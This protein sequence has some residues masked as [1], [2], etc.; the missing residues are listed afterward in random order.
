MAFFGTRF[1]R[2]GGRIDGVSSPSNLLL[3]G[4]E[5]WITDDSL[6]TV[7]VSDSIGLRSRVCRVAIANPNST[8][9]NRYSLMHRV[10]VVDEF[11]LITFSGRVIDKRPDFGRSELHLTCVDYLSDISDTTILADDDG[12]TYSGKSRAHIINQILYNEIW[13]SLSVGHNIGGQVF[14]VY[15]DHIRTLLSRV[16]MD[17]SNYVEKLT[18]TYSTK[19]YWTDSNVNP[20]GP[21]ALNPDTPFKYD[22]RGIKTGLE[23]IQDLAS[24][25]NQQ[26]L[27]VLGMVSGSHVEPNA[28]SDKK[29]TRYWKDFTADINE[30]E[31]AFVPLNYTVAHNKLYIGS[32]SKFNG[33]TYTFH[34]RGNSMGDSDYGNDTLIW[35]YWD[36]TQWL[37]FDNEIDD[38]FAA[39]S[40]DNYGEIYWDHTTL[41]NWQRRDLGATRDL[42]L[43]NDDGVSGDYS[44]NVVWTSN[45]DSSVTIDGVAIRGDEVESDGLDATMGV[46]AG[47]AHG[48]VDSTYRY[49]IR[50][51]AGTVTTAGRIA[52]LKLRTDRSHAS[53]ELKGVKTLVRDFRSTDPVFPDAIW[54]YD[55]PTDNS[56]LAAG[57]T[58]TDEG[59][60][61]DGKKVLWN[62]ENPLGSEFCKD[63]TEQ[64]FIGTE[65]PHSGFEFHAVQGAKISIDF[66]GT[67]TTNA[68]KIITGKAHGLTTGDFVL[69]TG[70][71]CEPIIDNASGK[72]T[73]DAGAS[74]SVDPYAVTV[75]NTTTFT[76]DITSNITGSMT[77]TEA[78]S[79]G[80]V[81]SGI[82]NYGTYMTFEQLLGT[83]EGEWQSWFYGGSAGQMTT[84]N[85]HVG[86]SGGGGLTHAAWAWDS[87]A[88]GE[89]PHWYAEVRLN[90]RKLRSGGEADNIKED[91]G[92]NTQMAHPGLN[93]DRDYRM[94]P[95]AADTGVFVPR[96][97]VGIGSV[98]TGSGSPTRLTTSA[99]HNL[100][101]GDWV[102]LSSTGT[103]PKI[104]GI[105]KILAINQASGT[106]FDVRDL[107]VTTSGNVTCHGYTYPPN[108][109]SLYWTK[110]HWTHATA[111]TNP[112]ILASI[113][114]ANQAKLKYFDRGKEPWKANRG[115]ASS[116]DATAAGRYGW[117]G[118]A[119][120][121]QTPLDFFAMHD[122]SE[123]KLESDAISTTSVSKTTNNPLAAGGTT[124]GLN[125]TTAYANANADF[126]TSGAVE[127]YNPTASTPTREIVSYTGRGTNQLTGVTRGRNGTTA[128]A[129]L[130]GTIVSTHV[131]GKNSH[132]RALAA[133]SFEIIDIAISDPVDTT[134]TI[135]VAHNMDPTE[136][137]EVETFGLLAGDLVNLTGT[138]STPVIN[139]TNGVIT[140]VLTPTVANTSKFTITHKESGTPT[141]VTAAGGAGTCA[142]PSTAIF[143]DGQ[144]VGDMAFFGS[145]EPFTQLRFDVVSNAALGSADAAFVVAW[146]YFKSDYTWASLE[147]EFDGTDSFKCAP[148]SSAEVHWIMPVDWRPC[149]PGMIDNTASDSGVDHRAGPRAGQTG[150]YVRAR[151]TTDT[152]TVAAVTVDQIL[153]GPNHWNNVT[154]DT[155]TITGVTD[156]RHS[157]PLKHGLTLTESSFA[158]EQTMQMMGYSVGD[159]ASEFVNKVVV[160]GQAGAYG[161]A[162]D[163]ESIDNFHV[164]KE[165]NYYD[166]TITNSVQAESRAN[167]ILD[168]LK[169]SG[170]TQS[171]R[172]CHVTTPSWPLY[173]IN[174][175][176]R[177]TQVG[178]RVN[179]IIPTKGIFNEPWLLAAI[180][181]DPLA[182]ICEMIFYRDLDRLI[183]PGASDKKILRDLTS[184]T[185]EL[186]RASF[187]TLDSVV[188]SGMDFLPEG[189]SRIVSRLSYDPVGTFTSVTTGGTTDSRAQ[190]D[191]YRWNLNVYS[192]YAANKPDRAQMRIDTT[193]VRPDVVEIEDDVK[194]P[195]DGAGLTL[196]GRNQRAGGTDNNNAAQ[197]GSGAGL[198]IDN[199]SVP[200]PNTDAEAARGYRDHFY[201]EDQEATI[202]LRKHDYAPGTTGALVG[203]G[204]YVAHRGIFNRNTYGSRDDLDG[205]DGTRFPLDLHHELF[206]GVSGVARVTNGNNG[207][208]SLSKVLPDLKA[209][210]MVFL[211]VETSRHT[212]QAG[213]Y[214]EIDSWITATVNSETVY[215]GFRIAAKTADGTEYDETDGSGLN[216][217]YLAVFNSARGG[218]YY[219][220]ADA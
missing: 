120:S 111:P 104:D 57:G 167:R 139:V 148:N 98:A 117:D 218:R 207:K 85:G 18:A 45:S 197:E 156:T 73:N 74:V 185:R 112:A 121:C 169:P 161:T 88:V 211:Q 151:I 115:T 2:A 125:T 159:R 66:I 44:E 210:P 110:I 24:T 160:R 77:V 116:F 78:G 23:A 193:S 41:Y 33:L 30:G 153:Y 101:V 94:S 109:K 91:F 201:P 146:E 38:E 65:E 135:T 137:Y 196:L 60:N 176:P 131:S 216:I 97:A 50:V 165:K 152:G 5:G 179:I 150:F 106:N 75:I 46:S 191:D 58:W 143:P 177:A 48:L 181:F 220:G 140:D 190:D 147:N 64:W 164:T 55:N 19:D 157:S 43:N 187:T 16:G 22:Y 83:G 70:T 208:V 25:D 68:I 62:D 67:N 15:H 9:E 198:N 142:I 163:E 11:G 95:F 175:H 72:I 192:D 171:I 51:G 79:V 105:Y 76:I 180:N 127:L 89:I 206:V 10:R 87:G 102:K 32:N 126:P 3:Q 40:S 107:S 129:H 84:L 56:T 214:A 174:G 81:I 13:K 1:Q 100:K 47:T 6:V 138:D 172:E 90:T 93:A 173:S 154:K 178:D 114:T 53:D 92:I 63:R 144:A 4:S 86:G 205:V 36:G 82:P 39:K 113:R 34:Q 27:M 35:D 168:T 145:H 122:A 155:G 209:R 49:W 119:S 20:S 189:P 130:T 54:K 183:E 96:T 136:T 217:M 204:L 170:K 194:Y 99:A 52:S 219:V 28:P 12:G 186:A 158:G 128:V 37:Q 213:C 123:D 103:T 199:Q 195:V 166:S 141:N 61:T 118:T 162:I 212:T 134:A 7:S 69:L 21:G 203:N 132:V 14:L 71:D 215:R 8:R 80:T 202:Y 108:G 133:S 124:I 42:G 29:F 200:V 182:S 59:V 188:E 31:A 184:R 149:Q 26:D 17:P